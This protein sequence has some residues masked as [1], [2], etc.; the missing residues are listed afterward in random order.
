MADD[1]VQEDVV[2]QHL[3]KMQSLRTWWENRAFTTAVEAVRVI[4]IPA[5]VRTV[6]RRLKQNG[7]R[8]HVAAKKMLLTLR[9]REVKIGFVLK[10]LTPDE[11]FCSRVGFSDEKVFQSSRDGCIKVYRPRNSRY[12]SRDIATNEQNI[13]FWVNVWAWI[14]VRSTAVML[15]CE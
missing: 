1:E 14:S 10:H 6:Q 11:V 3:K 12:N 5:S 13:R 4:H 8:N 2:H 15:H 7:L 9:H